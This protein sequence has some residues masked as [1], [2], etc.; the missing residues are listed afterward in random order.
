M[1]TIVE[2]A[3]YLVFREQP[4]RQFLLMR[5]ADRWD[6]PKGHVDRGES[7]LQTADRELREETGIRSSDFRRVE[8]FLFQ[9]QYQVKARKSGKLR[10]KKVSIFLAFLQRDVAI[11]PTEHPDF[12]WFDWAPPHQIQSQTIDPLLAFTDAFF[13]QSSN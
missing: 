9:L 11:T 6:L 12:Q 8:D 5:H 2:A 10:Q 3:G 7:I 13:N 1:P 4:Q